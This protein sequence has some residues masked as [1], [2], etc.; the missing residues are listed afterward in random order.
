MTVRQP[1]RVKVIETQRFFGRFVKRLGNSLFAHGPCQD[2]SI[3]G[4]SRWCDMEGENTC[5]DR[6]FWTGL[7]P[8]HDIIQGARDR[9]C[10]EQAHVI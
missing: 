8:K 7:R 10:K 4:S 2:L 9:L 5:L 1:V 6:L 3:R